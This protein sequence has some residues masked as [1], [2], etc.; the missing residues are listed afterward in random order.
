MERKIEFRG[1][2]IKTKEWH[3]GSL[4]SKYDADACDYCEYHILEKFGYTRSCDWDSN[5]VNVDF[6]KVDENTIGQYVGLKDK[7]GNKIY[8]GD[9]VLFNNQKGKIVYECGSFGISI[10]EGINYKRIEKFTKDNLDNS[11]EGTFCDNF[12]PLFELYWNFNNVDDYIDEIEV[13]GN[14]YD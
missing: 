11:F 3:Y 1:K 4:V 8:E 7:N 13:V 2:D 9:L 5:L 12:I 14:I 6:Y 10:E